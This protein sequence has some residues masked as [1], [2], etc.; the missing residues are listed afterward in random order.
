MSDVEVELVES[1]LSWWWSGREGEEAE[2]C[3]LSPSLLLEQ[4]VEGWKTV[5]LDLPHWFPG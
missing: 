5:L 1:V 4:L 2:L 3:K